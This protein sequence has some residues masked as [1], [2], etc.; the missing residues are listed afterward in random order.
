MPVFTGASMY[1]VLPPRG[2]PCGGRGGSMLPA[3]PGRRCS[4]INLPDWDKS[5]QR[6]LSDLAA[7]LRKESFAAEFAEITAA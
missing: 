6:H 7:L 1:L 4:G 3:T 5:L 2:G